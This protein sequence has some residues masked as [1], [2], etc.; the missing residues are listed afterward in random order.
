MISKTKNQVIGIRREWRGYSIV[1]NSILEMNVSPVARLILAWVVGR[2]DGWVL[3]LGHMLS[4]LRLSESVWLRA[5]KEI[6]AA[7]LFEQRRVRRDDGT[8]AWQNDFVFGLEL[9][10]GD[11]T[12][13]DAEDA[14]F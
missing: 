5:R 6:I 12:I 3:I 11:A 7:G 14:A 13:P 10:A 4:T 1:P 8:L 9:L 2:P